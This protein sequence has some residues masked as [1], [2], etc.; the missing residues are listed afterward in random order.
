MTTNQCQAQ[1]QGLVSHEVILQLLTHAL[2]VTSSPKG[3][4]NQQLTISVY[5]TTFPT[6]PSQ[7]LNTKL[8]FVDFLES[9]ES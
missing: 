9:Q 3:H 7:A 8:P 1:S 5:S 6:T 2:V 4:H